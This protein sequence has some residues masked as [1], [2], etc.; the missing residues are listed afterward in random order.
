M[1]RVQVRSHS[2]QFAHET[3]LSLTHFGDRIAEIVV[4]GDAVNLDAFAARQPLQFLATGLR[5]VERIAVRPLTIDLHAV[6]AEFF[7]GTNEFRQSEGFA[8]IP[9]A[10]IGDAIESNFHKGMSGLFEFCRGPENRVMNQRA[11]RR[12]TK[13]RMVVTEL[14]EDDP[15]SAAWADPRDGTIAGR[16]VR[17]EQWFDVRR[18]EHQTTAHHGQPDQRSYRRANVLLE[19]Q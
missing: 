6:V 14:N 7:G 8:A 4:G 1:F 16:V 17:D 9:A 2:N 18:N 3:D 10:E 12:M 19:G 13:R 15:G 5:P 11:V